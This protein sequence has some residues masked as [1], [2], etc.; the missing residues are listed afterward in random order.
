[1]DISVKSYELKNSTTSTKAMAT[2]TFGGVF[3]IKNV[4]IMEGKNGGMFVAMPSYKTKEVDEAGK[5]VYKDICNPVTKEFRE[6]LYG[7]I[8]ESY[9]TG[10]EVNLVVGEKPSERVDARNLTGT[11]RPI[12]LTA[13]PGFFPTEE[14]LAGLDLPFDK[15]EQRDKGEAPR[16]EK[17][18]IKD[19][20]AKGEEKKAEAGKAKEAKDGTTKGA[21][22]RETAAKSKEPVIA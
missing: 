19:K 16:K 3:K 2:I 17:G 11:E 15:G 8:L 18:S 20:L 1:M 7:A 21:A 9:R 14:E 10:K 5:A 22:G 4:S 12:R 6:A 13:D